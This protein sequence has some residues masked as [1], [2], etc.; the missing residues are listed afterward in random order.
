MQGIFA[1]AGMRAL[2]EAIQQETHGKLKSLT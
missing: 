2:C 1:D